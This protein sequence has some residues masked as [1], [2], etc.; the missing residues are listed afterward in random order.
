MGLNTVLL[1]FEASA[2]RAKDSVD[3]SFGFKLDSVVNDSGDLPDIYVTAATRYELK[4][5]SN[6]LI[7]AITVATKLPLV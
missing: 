4:L 3:W 2:A 7:C 6:R 1:G 5:L